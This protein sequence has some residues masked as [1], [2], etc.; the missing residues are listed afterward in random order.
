MKASSI[1]EQY[2]DSLLNDNNQKLERLDTIESIKEEIE[3]TMKEHLRDVVLEFVPEEL[4]E[5]FGDVD[6]DVTY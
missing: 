3:M 4:R 6:I 5:Y 1:V 2:H